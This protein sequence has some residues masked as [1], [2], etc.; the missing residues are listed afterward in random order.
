MIPP[1]ENHRQPEA[2]RCVNAAGMPWDH[3]LLVGARLASASLAAIVAFFAIRA[4]LGLRRRNL[5]L[6]SAGAATL[7]AGYFLEGVLV[8][9]GTLSLHAATV[10][11]AGFTLGAL[12]MLVASLYVRE[13]VLKFSTS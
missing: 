10:L 3:T 1:D 6:L 5:L 11:E 2:A 12:M 13:P 7:A 4:Y 8:E 9:S